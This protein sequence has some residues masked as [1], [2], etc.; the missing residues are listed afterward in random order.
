MLPH[1]ILYIPSTEGFKILSQVRSFTFSVKESGGRNGRQTWSTSIFLTLTA[2][3]WT[4]S[5]SVTQLTSRATNTHRVQYLTRH[6][7]Q[8]VS[9]EAIAAIGRVW[10]A[11][12]HQD[13]IYPDV[14]GYHL[15]PFL[16][17]LSWRRLCRF[18]M[19]AVT[20]W[21]VKVHEGCQLLGVLELTN[22]LLFFSF[23]W[24]GSIC[25][26]CFLLFLPLRFTTV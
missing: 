15:S 21:T 7:R 1:I 11:L 6:S 24:F 14:F 22:M 25:H 26:W 20:F 3:V 19:S 2:A 9:Q 12:C 16:F 5:R 4:Q 10:T 18:T 13:G 8:T 23:W 17:L